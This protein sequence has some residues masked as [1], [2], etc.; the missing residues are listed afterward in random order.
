[1]QSIT[2]EHWCTG[3]LV[4]R[5][6]RYNT[7]Q[8]RDVRTGQRGSIYWDFAYILINLQKEQDLST[9]SRQSAHL[10]TISLQVRLLLSAAICPYPTLRYREPFDPTYCKITIYRAPSSTFSH[11]Q[12]AVKLSICLS[13]PKIS[14][15]DSSMRKK[16]G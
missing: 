5:E 9:E 7:C 4:E 8:Q 2:S 11:K 12:S 3:P 13:A 1:M 15:D 10:G 14:F 16:W 6:S